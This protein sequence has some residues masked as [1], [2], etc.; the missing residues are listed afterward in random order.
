MDT[1]ESR[2]RYVRDGLSKG[3]VNTLRGLF[4]N[5]DAERQ[6]G[7][8]M[9]GADAAVRANLAEL[10]NA[11]CVRILGHSVELTP[12]GKDIVALKPES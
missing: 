10:Q 4:M 9:L 2:A 8:Y 12:L 1:N 7:V 11:A 3:A 5:T 6:E